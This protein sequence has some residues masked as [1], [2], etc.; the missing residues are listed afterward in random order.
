MR[1]P[2][3]ARDAG[4]DGAW[5]GVVPP[6]G[7]QLPGAEAAEAALAGAAAQPAPTDA[8]PSGV[9]S[10]AVSSVGV[11]ASSTGAAGVAW[12]PL[13]LALAGVSPWDAE[14]LGPRLVQDLLVAR[15]QPILGAW[16]G[17]AAAAYAAGVGA[18]A[19]MVDTDLDFRFLASSSRSTSAEAR[20]AFVPGRDTLLASP[21]VTVL[22]VA[23][24]TAARK[25]RGGCCERQV[26]DPGAAHW[27]G[28]R[29]LAS[30][31]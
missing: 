22:T 19:E 29:C 16:R 27:H 6:G 26:H 17:T 5:A 20:Q 13:L 15:L 25:R 18:T 7:I 3:A 1:P 12:N 21:G 8:T 14:V 10:G 2:E 24:P 9:P 4:S 31:E 11:L 28:W 30:R 23:E